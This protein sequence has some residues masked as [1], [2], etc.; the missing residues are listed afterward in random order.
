MHYHL[1]QNTSHLHDEVEEVALQGV[2]L[3][4]SSHGIKRFGEVHS[5][6]EGAAGIAQRH[7]A[8]LA[9]PYGAIER[10]LI[11]DEKMV[12]VDLFFMGL[13]QDLA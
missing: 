13:F 2:A 7:F 8:Y 10:C 3:S 5:Y 12:C 1:L 11:V 9:I 6:L 4:E